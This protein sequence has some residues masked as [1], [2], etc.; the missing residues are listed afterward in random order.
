MYPVPREA[1]TSYYEA[2][3]ESSRLSRTDGDLVMAGDANVCGDPTPTS[4]PTKANSSGTSPREA[5]TTL[6]KTATLA[7]LLSALQQL[8]PL[9]SPLPPPSKHVAKHPSTP[10]DP[11]TAPLT[12]DATMLQSPTLRSSSYDGFAVQPPQPVSLT[13]LRPQLAALRKN[14]TR[15]LSLEP[16]SADTNDS[17]KLPPPPPP[18]TP[19]NAYL[20]LSQQ[21]PSIA[22]TAF[23]FGVS[24]STNPLQE[25]MRSKSDSG[26]P[27]FT[28]P[29]AF[30]QSPLD[31][32]GAQSDKT[33]KQ[34]EI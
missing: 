11:Q 7:P 16:S 28:L 25:H 26:V 34:A 18:P 2:N 24:L 33:L 21:A 9:A 17:V 1:F 8:A 27:L 19:V 23:N 31:T 22:T 12:T 29:S 30:F 13:S 10:V 4:S 20:P 5:K 14:A 15:S 32:P 3:M 6:K